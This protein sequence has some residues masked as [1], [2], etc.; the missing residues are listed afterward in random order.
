MEFGKIDVLEEAG[1]DF[2]A[3]A[4]NVH[5]RIMAVPQKRA[6]RSCAR[7]GRC[8]TLG[9]VG[10]AGDDGETVLCMGVSVVW[11]WTPEC[12]WEWGPWGP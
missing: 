4:E 3:G 7:F 12:S 6:G 5:P 1:Q 11:I 9:K 8:A 2:G 10:C